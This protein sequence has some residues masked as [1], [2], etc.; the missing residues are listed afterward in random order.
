MARIKLQAC[1]ESVADWDAL[2]DE[3]KTRL[4]RAFGPAVTAGVREMQEELRARDPREKSF[5]E[6]SA[7]ELAELGR[8]RG[9][10]RATL[11]RLEASASVTAR[12]R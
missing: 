12:E 2:S 5:D 6:L 7:D 11:A 3:Q 4:I 9:Q 1:R 10:M 8:I